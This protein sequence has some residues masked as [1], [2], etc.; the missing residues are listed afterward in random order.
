MNTM[1]IPGFAAEASL[2]KTSGHYQSVTTQGN[3]RGGAVIPQLGVGGLGLGGLGVGG[4]GGLGGGSP[5]FTSGPNANYW[6]NP[7]GSWGCAGWG[8][9]AN[10]VKD[11]RVKDCHCGPGWVT[12]DPVCTC[13]T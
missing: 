1:N 10:L 12:G 8:D 2:Y 9:C 13:T 4:L 3:S 6:H 5:I 11:V 7:D